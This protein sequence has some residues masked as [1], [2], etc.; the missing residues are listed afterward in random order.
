[1]E[2]D[3]NI[4]DQYLESQKKLMDMWSQMAQNYG[5]NF[6]NPLLQNPAEQYQKFFSQMMGSNPFQGYY[7]SPMEVV[8]KLGQGSEV[9]YNIYKLWTEIYSKNIEPNQE[10]FEKLAEDVKAQSLNLLNSYVMPYLPENLQNTVNESLNMN[11]TF[12]N[13]MQTI[14]GPWA[15]SVIELSDAF[16]KGAFKDPEGFLEYFNKWRVNYDK[17]FNKFLQMPQMGI[18]RNEQAQILEA[19]D[20]YIK[21][22][23]Y[24]TQFMVR[25]N[26]ILKSTTN[27]VIEKSFEDLKKGE[28]PKTFDEFYKFF[29][30]T[31]SAKFDE[32]FLT[33]EFSTLLATF[34]NSLLDLKIATDKVV[35]SQLKMLPIPVKSDMDSLYKT[36]YELKKE[37]RAMQKQIAKMESE[38]QKPK[39]TK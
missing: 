12:V 1:M 17:T 34:T 29:K 18:Q 20:K 8:G 22:M 9:Y 3:F 21:F 26:A 11:N 24:F 28:Q 5:Q 10:N 23:V 27:E 31:I 13:T 35:E 39:E 19:T 33:G 14:Y 16:M 36:V 32:I 6:N 38:S 25:M 15:E 37:V 2:N 4:F 7:G 30:K